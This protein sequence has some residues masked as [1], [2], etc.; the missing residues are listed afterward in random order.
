MRMVRASSPS[1]A[2]GPG[3]QKTSAQRANGAQAANISPA[4]SRTYASRSSA[5]SRGTTCAPR[6]V[7]SAVTSP[8]SRSARASS[9]TVSP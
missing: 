2:C 8:A 3:S 5:N 4:T 7:V 1:N 9:S 6:Y